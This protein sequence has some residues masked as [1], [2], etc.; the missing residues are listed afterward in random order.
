M[1]SLQIKSYSEA[2]KYFASFIPKN[3]S[4]LGSYNLDT[5][6]QIMVELGNPQEKYRVIHV[7]GTS[8]KT[9]T[10]YFIAAL[11]RQSGMKVGLTISPHVDLIAERVQINNKIIPE[12][13]FCR[14]LTEFSKL[15]K[16][17]T[18]R[19]TYF[20]LL[21][22]FT[23]WEFAR[24]RVDY[25]VVEVGMGGLLDGTNVIK[26]SDKVC[27]ITDI[28]LDHTDILG[29]T[30]AEIARQKAGIVHSGN[31]VFTYH[32]DNQADRTIKET[33]ATNLGLLHFVEQPEFGKQLE[34]P[35]FQQ[36]NWFLAEKVVDYVLK[37]DNL[38]ELSESQ[39]HHAASIYIPARMEVIK[40]AG[41][42]LIMDGS[43]NEQKMR[44]LVQS[45]QSKYPSVVFDV[46]L[47]LTSGKDVAAVIT[48]LKPIIGHITITTFSG[49]QD[50]PKKAIDPQIIA[51]ACES[52][53]ITSV[54]IIKNPEHA[55]EILQES[56]N[57][58]K[59]VTGSFFLLNHVRPALKDKGLIE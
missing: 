35:L 58:Y 34:L 1:E 47:A 16:K 28:G 31:T 36:R 56:N 30:V 55:F 10:A 12:K 32:Q 4:I 57:K 26:R 11:L 7:A 13:T 9:S 45:I 2:E 23:F 54:K 20:E 44:A 49:Q 29:G 53:G 19:P 41:S 50:L 51:D 22:A 21:V 46:M 33:V 17:L 5:M 27:V 43:H 42:I 18:V 14:E 59:L 15:L 48:E 52:E 3:S 6:N 37:R 38:P 40:H 24:Q 8:G 39:K 25:A